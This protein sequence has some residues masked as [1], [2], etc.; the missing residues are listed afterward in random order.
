MPIRMLRDWTDSDKMNSISVHAERFFV[1]LIMKADDFGC[2]YAEPRLLSAYLFPLIEGVRDTDI[3]RWMA[4]CQKAGLIVNY[5]AK[6]KRFLQI[7][8]FNQRMRQKRSNFQMPA[9]CQHDDSTMTAEC[10]PE[11]EN[12]YE[13]E[14]EGEGKSATP[15]PPD[16][17]FT[18]E[19]KASFK[20]FQEWIV[21]FAPRVGKMKEPF[22]INQYLA[23]KEK[24]W[25]TVKIR[26][27]LADMHNW[28]DLHKK[29]VSAYLTLLNWKRRD[30]K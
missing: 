4:E 23:L 27:L 29:R 26:E 25:S 14:K 7:I 13:E 21:K 12:E 24:G 2:Y 30:E 1:R 10:Q 5:E 15:P 19:E 11:I 16:Q 22:T 8:D 28:A 17:V 18:D 6:G 3:T 20:N 9:S